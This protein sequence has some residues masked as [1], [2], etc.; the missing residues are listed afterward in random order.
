MPKQ[1]TEAANRK[2]PVHCPGEFG[3]A[4]TGN[5][6]Q[7]GPLDAGDL[8]IDAALEVGIDRRDHQTVRV[9]AAE[10]G[11]VTLQEGLH[12]RPPPLVARIVIGGQ[13]RPWKAATQPQARVSRHPHLVDREAIAN[14]IYRGAGQPMLTHVGPSDPDFLTIYDIDRGSGVTYDPELARELISEEMAAAGAE[15]VDGINAVQV[16]ARRHLSPGDLM[17]QLE[18]VAPRAIAGRQKT[19]GVLR[20][21]KMAT[22]VGY[23]MTMGHL[24]DRVY[25]RDQW[26][27]RVDIASATDH[28]LVLTAEHDGRIV[29]DVVVVG[30]RDHVKPCA[31]ARI[32]K[33]FVQFPFMRP[34]G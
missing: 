6:E 11:Q 16:E 29:E 5:S 12:E 26:M 30:H 28:D 27:H 2:S 25:T 23:S 34:D 33:Q 4:G 15:L 32:V 18:A 20:R 3:V 22:G 13:E 17:S 8:D 14:D 31:V 7:A 21:I 9:A 24:V 10:L 1:A 19:P